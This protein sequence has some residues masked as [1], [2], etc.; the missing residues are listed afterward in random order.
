NDFRPEGPNFAG[1]LFEIIF[2]LE[3]DLCN[4]QVSVRRVHNRNAGALASRIAYDL[5]FSVSEE[6]FSQ[7][8]GAGRAKKPK[9]AWDNQEYSQLSVATRP[10]DWRMVQFGGIR[11]VLS[12]RNTTK[13]V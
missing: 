4:R 10:F 9:S 8:V 5:N 6:G 12:Q 3:V 2:V 1:N 11:C 7:I 13:N